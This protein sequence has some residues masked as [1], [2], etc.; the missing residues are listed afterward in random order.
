[1]QNDYIYYHER[2]SFLLLIVQ[3][4]PRRNSSFYSIKILNGWEKSLRNDKTVKIVSFKGSLTRFKKHNITWRWFSNSRN[5]KRKFTFYVFESSAWTSFERPRKGVTSFLLSMSS[6]EIVTFSWIFVLLKLLFKES[7]MGEEGG[8][9]C[10]GWEQVSV[11]TA[12]A[13]LWMFHLSN[14]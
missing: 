10:F 3:T 8:G 4:K 1:M 5:R 12:D 7:A 2:V 14:T 11:Q 6:Y 13:C 9:R